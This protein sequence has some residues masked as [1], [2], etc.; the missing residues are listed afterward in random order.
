MTSPATLDPGRAA[1]LRRGSRGAA[2]FGVLLA[3]LVVRVVSASAEELGEGDRLREA[4]DLDAAIVHYRRSARWYAPASPYPVEA[5]TRLAEIGGAAEEADETSRAL[6]AYRAIRAS[7]MSTRS[8]Y[9]PHAERLEAAND[10]IATLM[11]SLPPPPI[12]A[13]KT[14]AQLREEHL[15]L[16]TQD[17]RPDLG[18]T[19]VL[20]FGFFAWVA[21]AFAFASKAIDEEDRIQKKPALRYGAVVLVGFFL[22]VVGML[23]A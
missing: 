8:F 17:R 15:A 13:G 11:A 3:V 21:G 16:L 7:I 22:F 19:V 9:T 6:S 5:L 20:L 10:R 2:V 18:W 1:W 12:D 23:L 14:P 4:G